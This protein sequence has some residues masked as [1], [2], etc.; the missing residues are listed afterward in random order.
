MFK[1]SFLS[2]TENV[3]LDIMVNQEKPTV[4]AV[5]SK[6]IVLTDGSVLYK[7]SI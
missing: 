5:R 6:L 2:L 7:V 1:D 3:S 4:S